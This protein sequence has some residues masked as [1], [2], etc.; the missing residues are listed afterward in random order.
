MNN[1]I[2]IPMKLCSWRSKPLRKDQRYLLRLDLNVPLSGKR[3]RNDYKLRAAVSTLTLF[4]SVPVIIMTHLGEP[5]QSK[6]Y[7]YQ[8]RYS[9]TPLVSYLSKK[10]PGKVKKASGSWTEVKKQ[11]QALKPGEILILENLRF[12]PGE[13]TNDQTFAKQLASLADVYINDAFAV[14]HRAHASVSAI[15]RH[16]PAFAGPGLIEEVSHLEKI[17]TKK[18]L[19]LVLGGAKISTKLPVITNLLP[20]SKYVL[21]GGAMANTILKARGYE[22]GASM[23]DAKEMRL[24]KS[25]RSNKIVIPSD[26]VVMQ[27]TKMR[28]TSIK[29]VSKNEKIVDIGPGTIKQ[30]EAIIKKS[31]AMVWNGPLGVIE[32]RNARKGTEKII[33]AMVSAT[34]KGGFSVSGGGETVEALE[35]F[36][37]KKGISWVSTG[38]GAS[39]L[40]LSGTL[41]PGLKGLMSK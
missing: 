35:M 22:I 32:N 14:S 31:K 27:G 18:H 24:A 11:S 7:S 37:K 33:T 4:R 5:E 10:F 3:I 17:F 25:L 6:K 13:V 39:L 9:V 40:F 41:L 30:Y 38:G 20:H 26:V 19:T 23:Y 15:T 28:V 16:L 1:L 36:N 21:I 8:S 12:W 34:K 29:K 2:N